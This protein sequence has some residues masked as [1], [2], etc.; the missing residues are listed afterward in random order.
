MWAGQ[1]RT[2]YRPW[3]SIR[4]ATSISAGKPC[5]PISLA[6]QASGAFQPTLDET[7]NNN[8][9]F[10]TKMNP[11][12]HRSR[13]QFQEGENIVTLLVK[14]RTRPAAPCV[15]PRVST[16]AASAPRYSIQHIFV[17]C[18]ICTASIVPEQETVTGYCFAPP[19]FLEAP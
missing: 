9:G 5:P 16:S 10:V 13:I 2:A 3:R 8:F 11:S 12:G 19:P 6:C 1:I 17:R 18:S 14:F 15:R 4:M 7:S